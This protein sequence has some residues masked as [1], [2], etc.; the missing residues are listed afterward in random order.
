VLEDFVIDRA[1]I[2]AFW[3]VR[4]LAVRGD[5]NQRVEHSVYTLL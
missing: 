3:E 1:G 5:A 4:N 2:P